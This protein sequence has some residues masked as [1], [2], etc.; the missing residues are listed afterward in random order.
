MVVRTSNSLVVNTALEDDT[1]HCPTCVE[2]EL[3]ILSQVNI[4]T[5]AE[6]VVHLSVEHVVRTKG[7]RVVAGALVC[8]FIPLPATKQLGVVTD[9]VTTLNQS[10]VALDG[11]TVA[12]ANTS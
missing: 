6:D 1:V 9:E 12:F 2:C 7:D 5:G 3:D 8:G 10:T 11:T 4:Q